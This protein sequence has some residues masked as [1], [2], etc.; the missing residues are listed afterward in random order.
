VRVS[1]YGI[2]GQELATVFDGTLDA[3]VHALPFD[4]RGLASGVYF[5][6]MQTGGFH[7]TKSMLLV[8]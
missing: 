4:A 3:G 8:R 1:V 7:A 6:L 5:Y 2:L